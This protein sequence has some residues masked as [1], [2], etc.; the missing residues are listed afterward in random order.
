MAEVPET[1]RKRK[2]V[3]EAD[4][5]TPKDPEVE[6]SVNN[7]K[8]TMGQ[9]ICHTDEKGDPNASE[10]VELKKRKLEQ[11]PEMIHMKQTVSVSGSNLK[12]S[13]HVV[14]LAEIMCINLRVFIEMYSRAMQK[15][16]NAQLFCLHFQN[17]YSSFS[18]ACCNNIKSIPLMQ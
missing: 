1:G 12:A 16:N 14:C 5:A 6:P 7:D 4:S 18:L 3:E 17:S 11:E 8:T 9:K 13:N 10:E 15:S 2:R